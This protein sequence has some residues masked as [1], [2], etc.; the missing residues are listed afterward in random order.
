[1][2]RL[3]DIIIRSF[4][5]I[6]LRSANFELFPFFVYLIPP[7]KR[8][9]PSVLYRFFSPSYTFG[10]RAAYTTPTPSVHRYTFGV[11]GRGAGVRTANTEGVAVKK[12]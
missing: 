10:V 1:M 12:R 4:H 8:W 9:Y 2:K 6:E 5:L 7:E 11:S 3:N